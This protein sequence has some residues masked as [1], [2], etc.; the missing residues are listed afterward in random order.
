MFLTNKFKL[1]SYA[2][3]E[4]G[5]WFSILSINSK[6]LKKTE[7]D[8]FEN[9]FMSLFLQ[10]NGYSSLVDTDWTLLYFGFPGDIMFCRLQNEM[11]KRSYGNKYLDTSIERNWNS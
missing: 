11:L 5:T 4:A 8:N 3:G 10:D 1:T 9:S 6:R 7:I 2:E